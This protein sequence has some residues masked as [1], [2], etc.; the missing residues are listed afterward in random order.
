M[1]T[2]VILYLTSLCSNKM[3]SPS[4]RNTKCR[5]LHSDHAL[6]QPFVPPT[7]STFLRIR[8]IVQRARDDDGERASDCEND[9]VRGNRC[10]D[11]STAIHGPQLPPARFQLAHT[12]P[13]PEP[14][15]SPSF[16]SRR[17]ATRLLIQMEVVLLAAACCRARKPPLKDGRTWTDRPRPRALFPAAAAAVSFSSLYP[18]NAPPSHSLRSLLLLVVLLLLVPSLLLKCELNAFSLQSRRPTDRP[19]E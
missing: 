10:D 8:E 12:M 15:Q 4:E 9:L 7:R 14:A 3:W 18:S 5:K 16:S 19:R 6:R 13:K 2:V 11:A 1:I 17:I